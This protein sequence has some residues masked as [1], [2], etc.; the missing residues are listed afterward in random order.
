MHVRV[1]AT[2]RD[3]VGVRLRLRNDARVRGD[4]RLAKQGWINGVPTNARKS[5]L[6]QNMCSATLEVLALPASKGSNGNREHM[7]VYNHDYHILISVTMII[8]IT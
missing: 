5:L 6:N 7:Q 4:L 3:R 1:R 8:S 2:M